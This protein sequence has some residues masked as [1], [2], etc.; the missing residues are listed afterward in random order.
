MSVRM[1]LWVVA[2]GALWGLTGNLPAWG[3]IYYVD[4]IKGN[5]AWS[6]FIPVALS[7]H[8]PKR[9]I[10]A[11]INVSSNCDTVI[12]LPGTFQGPENGNL[13][14]HGKQITLRSKNPTDTLVIDATIIDGGGSQRLFNFHSQEGSAAALDGLTITSG[15]A[16]QNGMGGAIYCQN[17]GPTIRRCR[18][19]SNYAAYGG[20]IYCG[21]GATPIIEECTFQLNQATSYGGGVCL[22]A[23][24]SPRITDCSFVNNQALENGGAVYGGNIATSVLEQCAFQSNQATVSGGGIYIATNST[25]Q[26]VGCLFENHHAEYGGAIYCLEGSTPVL[27][28]CTFRLNHA[29]LYGGGAYLDTNS[30]PVIKDCL[31]ENNPSLFGGGIYS[32]SSDGHIFDNIFRQNTVTGAG[33][34]LFFTGDATGV[35]LYRCVISGNSANDGAGINSF[36]ATGLLVKNCTIVGNR[37]LSSGGGAYGMNSHLTL[38]NCILWDN[39]AAPAKGDQASIQKSAG[40][41][42]SLTITYSAVAGG[43]GGIAVGSGA[44]LNWGA[45]NLTTNPQFG[46]S[47]SW[48]GTTWVEGDYHLKSTQGWWDFDCYNGDLT[49]DSWV[50]Y[51]DFAI[52][53]MNWLHTGSGLPA[54]IDK[55]NDVDQGDLILMSE[56]WLT[57][58]AVGRWRVDVVQSPAID[59]ADPNDSFAQELWPHGKRLDLGA[60]GGSVQASFSQN[61]IGNAADL[62]ND[63]RV[64]LSDLISWADDWQAEGWFLAADFQR[65]GRI[66]LLDFAQLAANW[67]WQGP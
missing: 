49:G 41:T 31:F 39:L 21:S 61:L 20:A 27:D 44:T 8:G 60:Y 47:G 42:A 11:A 38:R 59:A 57:D 13:D 1:W 40:K 36:D 46:Q 22:D 7:P 23:N 54:D 12:L 9:T 24:S 14:F 16:D 4:A 17:S 10:Q 67:L 30:C 53:A 58:G 52:L 50:N 18:L 66:D 56:K 34:G 64:N 35:Q 15:L 2:V 25:P 51:L 33:G 62:N 48:Q 45:N 32:Q 55:D 29:N 5:N 6:G 65:D 63:N 37:A 26:I 3:R 28:Q 19:R 43:T